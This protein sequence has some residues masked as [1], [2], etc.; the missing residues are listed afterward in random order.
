M[1]VLI[2]AGNQVLVVRIHSVISQISNIATV[3][4]G[5]G[6]ICL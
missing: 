6:Q 5:V 3:Y 1:K 4:L 2:E